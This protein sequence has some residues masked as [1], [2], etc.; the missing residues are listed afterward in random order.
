MLQSRDMMDSMR[1]FLKKDG[2][3]LVYKLQA[4]GW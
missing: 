3:Q 2:S 1:A 4:T